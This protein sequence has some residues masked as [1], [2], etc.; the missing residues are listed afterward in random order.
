MKNHCNLLDGGGI[1]QTATKLF[2]PIGGSYR[3][4]PLGTGFAEKGWEGGGGRQSKDISPSDDL[5]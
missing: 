2:A 4:I 5:S 3:Q 1:A